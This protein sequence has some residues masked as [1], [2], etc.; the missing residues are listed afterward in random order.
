MLVPFVAAFVDDPFPDFGRRVWRRRLRMPRR[1]YVWM[2]RT[3]CCDGEEDTWNERVRG[4]FASAGES[5]GR[6]DEGR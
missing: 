1:F 3:W 2:G 4:P 5:E 6:A